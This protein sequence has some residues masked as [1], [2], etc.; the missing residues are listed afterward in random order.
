VA[1][2]L[3]RMKSHCRSIL[4][5]GIAVGSAI[6]FAGEALAHGGFESETEVRVEATRMRVVV[7]T[8]LPFAWRMLGDRAPAA[9]DEPA[10]AAAKPLLAEAAKELFEVTAGGLPMSPLKADC[11]FEVHDLHDHAAFAID[12]ARPTA[13]PVTV[14]ATFFGKLGELDEGTIAVFDH[15]AS[16]FSRDVDPLVRQSIRAANPAVTFELTGK[17]PVVPPAANPAPASDAPATAAETSGRRWLLPVALVGALLAGG[18]ALVLRKR[19]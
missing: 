8:S 12:Y 4:A 15:T 19:S 14:K 3:R 17:L 2:P 1:F 13:W 10:K 11:H 9:A 16:R 7:R 18:L 5:L 6:L